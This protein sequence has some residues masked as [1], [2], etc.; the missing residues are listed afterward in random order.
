MAKMKWDI[1]GKGVAPTG[2]AGYT[3]PDLPKGSWPAK[4]KRMTVTKIK[5]EGANKGKPRI[6]VL[7]EVTGLT[8]D[9]EKYNGAPVWDGLNI[10][11]SSLSFVNAFLHGLTDGSDAAKKAIEAAFWDKDKG[12]DVKAEDNKSGDKVV[13]I[14]KIGAYNVNSPDGALMVQI[15]TKPGADLTGNYR[16]EITGYIPSKVDNLKDVD[17][18]DDFGDDDDDDDIDDIPDEDEDFEDEDDEDDELLTDSEDLPSGS[19]F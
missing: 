3:G 5:S 13:H 7:L 16:P 1:D 19:P 14:K 12:P 15:T 18:D 9:K 4:V 8:G 2:G 11:P 6:S 10:I 17:S